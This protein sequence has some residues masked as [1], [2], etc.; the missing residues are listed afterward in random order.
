[1]AIGLQGG[2]DATKA[3]QQGQVA[4]IRRQAGAGL[5]P[6]L[7][8]GQGLL[9]HAL[10]L[11][12][13]GAAAI[14]GGQSRLPDGGGLGAGQGLEGVDGL[15]KLASGQFRLGPCLAGCR[16][17]RRRLAGRARFRVIASEGHG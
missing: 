3:E 6:V 1:M 11:Q 15:A 14:G 16:G 10:G 17:R 4:G 5:G 12:F 13:Q 8:D 2:G 9:A 7:P